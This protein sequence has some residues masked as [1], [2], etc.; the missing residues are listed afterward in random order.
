[1]K[2]II[3]VALIQGLVLFVIIGSLCFFVR[4]D[5]FY[6]YLAPL[7]GGAAALVRFAGGYFLELM[8][9]EENKED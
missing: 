4:G 1:M 5:F 6:A 3:F 7:L 8:R 2:Q 9:P